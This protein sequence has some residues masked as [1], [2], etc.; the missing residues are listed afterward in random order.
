MRL[1]PKA[2]SIPLSHA[3]APVN[4][5]V[6]P[7]DRYQHAVLISNPSSKSS[8]P[9]LMVSLA[10]LVETRPLVDMPHF[11]LQEDVPVMITRP[12]PT[13]H[14]KLV[15]FRVKG[16]AAWHLP[17]KHSSPGHS[18]PGPEHPAARWAA[19]LPAR[20]EQGG[21]AC[22]A[23]AGSAPGAPSAG[24]VGT[25]A[26]RACSP[27]CTASWGS[28]GCKSLPA[29]S[30]SATQPCWRHEERLLPLAGWGHGFSLC[31]WEQ[32]CSIACRGTIR[33]RVLVCASG[34]VL[35][36]CPPAFA[37]HSCCCCCGV[38]TCR[39]CMTRALARY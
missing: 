27:P 30:M 36:L 4:V 37:Q 10:A 2:Q 11:P 1:E 28:C 22:P 9:R 35:A 24:C 5:S 6:T 21:S 20:G 26:A 16:S 29:A 39:L 7:G 14:I 13:R 38:L 3:E 19:A 12:D 31:G 17:N 15:T 18:S 32:A 23:Q 25:A 33:A 8:T 34:H